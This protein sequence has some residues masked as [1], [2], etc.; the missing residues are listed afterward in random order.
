MGEWEKEVVDSSLEKKRQG[1]RVKEEKW[2]RERSE[3]AKRDMKEERKEYR[4]MI[5]EKKAR[6][7]LEYLEKVKRGQGFGFVKTDR[8]LM[9]DVPAIRGEDGEMVREDK[10]KEREIVRGLG[11]REELEQEREG[12]WEDIEVE[13]E[14]IEEALWKQKDGKAAGVNELSGKVMKELWKKEWGKRVIIWVVEKSLG[15]GYVPRQF[16]DGIGVVMRKPN[17]EYYSLPSS[18]RVINLLDVWGKCLERVVVERLGNWEKEG[19]GEEQWGGRKGRSSLEA[20]AGLLMDW[21]KGEGLGL[22]LC[23]DVRGGYENVGVRK[24][25]ERMKGLGVDRYLRK[26]ISSFLRE[27]RSKV[28]IG[29]RVGDRVYLRGGTVQGSAWSPMLFMFLLGGVL[30]EVRRVEVEGVM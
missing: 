16:R 4:G 11:K 18:Y 26:W 29:S 13:E 20:V 8:D 25:K 17:K 15:L 10:D 23:I 22:L 6:Y 21:E 30:E 7:W 3:G 24:M 2:K 9:V 1:V 5:E 19:L 28:K 27:R 14:D 12:F